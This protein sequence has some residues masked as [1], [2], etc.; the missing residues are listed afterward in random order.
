MRSP[1]DMDCIQID[2][3][4]K[5]HLSCTHCTRLVGH[6]HQPYRLTLEGVENA[7]I[8]LKGFKGIIGCM[9]GEPASHPQFLDI[10]SLYKK[11]VPLGQRELWTAG[12]HWERYK[13]HIHNVFEKGLVSFNDHSDADKGWHQ[14]L[15]IAIEEILPDKKDEKLKNNLIKNCWVQNRWSAAITNKGAF[16]CEVAAAQNQLFNGPPGWKVEPGWWKRTPE[17]KDFKDQVKKYCNKCSACV[18]MP[19]IPNNHDPADWVSPGNA[20][21]LEAVGSPKFKQGRYKVMDLKKIREYVRTGSGEAGKDRGE[22]KDFPKW[23]PWNYRG[24]WHH[25]PGEGALTAKEVLKIQKG[26]E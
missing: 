3:T 8:S 26:K 21:R 15:L 20:K 22:L 1:A 6:H 24:E 18:P 5:C 13:E 11:H 4:N 10:I 14:P 7:L 17:D 9:G 23:T 12:L 25:E 19:M 2:V 16:F